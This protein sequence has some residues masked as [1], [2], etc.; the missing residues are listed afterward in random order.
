MASA[1]AARGPDA[2]GTITGGAG[3]ASMV[4]ASAPMRTS[5]QRSSPG[6]ASKP[7]RS[8]SKPTRSARSVD[9][10]VGPDTDVQRALDAVAALDGAGA[11]AISLGRAPAPDS[12]EAAKR[13]KRI[14]RA[15]AGPPQSVGDLDRAPIRRAVL[16]RLP[17]IK[18]CYERAL[19]T[20][21]DL[22]GTVSTQ[23][24]IAP[25]GTVMSANAAGVSPEVASCVAAIIKA[26]EFPKPRGGGGVQVN[27]PF[28]FRQ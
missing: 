11:L 6:A 12:P 24:F 20:T 3:T 15:S 22:A 18:A 17:Q 9:V 1:A 26:I 28:T 10:L 16:E 2:H 14:P 5:I 21:P 23:F 8:S 13:G 4:R 7:T 27:Y 25:N 19:V